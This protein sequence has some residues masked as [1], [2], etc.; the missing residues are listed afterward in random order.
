MPA[1]VRPG[2]FRRFGSAVLIAMIVATGLSAGPLPNLLDDN[3]GN[4]GL[5]A[6]ETLAFNTAIGALGLVFLNPI[7]PAFTYPPILSGRVLE[8]PQIHNLYLDSDW[9]SHNPDAP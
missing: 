6:I 4:V 7:S 5:A 1:P 9:D 2:L 3:R 8:H